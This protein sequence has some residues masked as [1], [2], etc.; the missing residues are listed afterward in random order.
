MSQ[1][2]IFYQMKKWMPLKQE[3]RETL[4]EPKYQNVYNCY[5]GNGKIVLCLTVYPY[6]NRFISSSTCHFETLD[7]I[8]CIYH[9]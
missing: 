6:S 3:K 5:F 1:L 7:P 4:A 8:F 2:L 9:T